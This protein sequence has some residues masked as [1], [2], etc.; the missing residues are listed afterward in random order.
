[1]SSKKEGGHKFS[2]EIELLLWG[3][4]KKRRRKLSVRSDP[5][6]EKAEDEISTQAP[7][8]LEFGLE[9]S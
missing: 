7:S 4:S 6:H 1:M 5:P 3:G 8:S 2:T 9:K